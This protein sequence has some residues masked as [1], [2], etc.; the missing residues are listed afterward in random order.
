MAGIR[1]T[2]LTASS[3]IAESVLRGIYMSLRRILQFTTAFCV[4][5]DRFIP[6]GVGTWR[7]CTRGMRPR[8]SFYR[9]IVLGLLPIYSSFNYKN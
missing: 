7:T 5:Y 4:V 2:G 3:A 8:Y 1:S 9:Q 6:P